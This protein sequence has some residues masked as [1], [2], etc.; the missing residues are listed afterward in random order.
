MSLKLQTVPAGHGALWVRLG[1]RTFFRQPMAFAALFAAFMFGVFV[2]A[3]VPFLGPLLVLA[4]LP[5]VSLAFMSATR[6]AVTGATPTPRVF[7]EPLRGPRPRVVALLQLGL[8]YAACTYA[9]MAMS[10]LADGGAFEALMNSLPAAGASAPGV[11]AA[12]G[13]AKASAAN[14]ALGLA[15][16]FGLAGLLSVPFWHAP[17]LICWGGHGCAKSLFA[18][19]LACWRNRGAFSMYSLVWLGLV[20]L[21]GM[22]GSLVFAL[23]GQSQLFALATVPLSLVFTTAFYVSLYFTFAD[24]FIAGD[25]TA[26][27]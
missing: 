10:D 6:I 27:S 7:V 2:L 17:A 11:P 9:V 22:V 24:C 21:L 13:G 25:A 3:L 5:L 19:T 20:L 18:S 1:L 12:I 15:L 26:P 23:L 4:L 16:R 8:L 14:L